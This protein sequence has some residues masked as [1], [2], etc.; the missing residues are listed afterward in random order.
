MTA[1]HTR[2]DRGTYCAPLE[3]THW[4]AKVGGQ[5]ATLISLGGP[6]LVNGTTYK[7]EINVKDSAGNQ[8][9]TMITFVTKSKE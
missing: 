9:Q 3:R 4:I 7:V 2:V 8:T 1:F 5:T 6:E